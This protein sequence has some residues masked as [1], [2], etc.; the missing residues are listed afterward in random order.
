MSKPSE[1]RPTW[2]GLWDLYE[3]CLPN[4]WPEFLIA[5]GIRERVDHTG[6]Y[7][8]QKQSTKVWELRVPYRRGHRPF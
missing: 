1:W 4:M 5:L 7:W 2:E 6:A 8:A 3:S